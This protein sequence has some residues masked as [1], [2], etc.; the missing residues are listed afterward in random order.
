MPVPNCPVGY[1]GP[2]GLAD[3]GKYVNCTGGAAGYL[4]RLI[5][6]SHMY[7][8]PSC[9]VMYETKVA[10]DP[11]GKINLLLLLKHFYIVLLFV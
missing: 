1:L 3:N 8:R 4:D 10:F 11:E 2:G 5:F 6:G 9:Y 7:K